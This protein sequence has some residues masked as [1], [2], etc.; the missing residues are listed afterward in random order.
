MI[1]TDS[2][3]HFLDNYFQVQ[4][5]ED[6]KTI[7]RPASGRVQRLG[8]ALEAWPGM[9]VWLT[10]NKIDALFLH[11]PWPLDEQS[12]PEHMGIVSSHRGFDE[13]LTLGFNP[14]L[15]E[16]LGMT[17]IS[18]LG[19]K[20]GRPCGMIGTVRMQSVTGYFHAVRHVFGGYEEAHTC[21]QDCVTRV[22][23]IGAMNKSLVHQASERGASVYIT[24][25]YRQPGRIGVLETGIGVV[26]VGHRRS[27]EWGMRALAGVLRER[28]AGLEVILAPPYQAK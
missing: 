22:A 1:E 24:G 18:V 7:I 21:E 3:A 23:V 12:L 28:W 19:K 4:Q 6:E 13:R 20:E 11:R 26:I 15:A 2:I 16:A 9:A 25:E 10:E 14:R 27:E 5:Y 17:A 8:V